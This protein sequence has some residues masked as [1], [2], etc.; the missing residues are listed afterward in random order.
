MSGS[1][2]ST[3]GPAQPGTTPD[4]D[5]WMARLGELPLLAQPGDRWL[6]QTGSQVLGVLVSRLVGAPLEVVLR[7][8]VLAP[9]GMEDTGSTQ[10]TVSGWRRRVRGRTASLWAPT[11]RTVSGRAPLRSPMAAPGWCPA[12]GTWS[13]SDVLLS[14]G[15]G[16][17]VAAAFRTNLR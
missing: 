5:T 12:W 16:V 7:E 17:L 14:G 15:G 10:P 13:L 1:E 11:H 9:L 6:Y 3:F 2:G 8:R 4:P